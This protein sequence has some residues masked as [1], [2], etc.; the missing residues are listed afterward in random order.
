MAADVDDAEPEVTELA[1]RLEGA[2]MLPFM[3]FADSTGQYLEGTSG[4]VHPTAFLET[5]KRLVA[6]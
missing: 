6:H 4:L 5:L 1:M 2:M 3:L